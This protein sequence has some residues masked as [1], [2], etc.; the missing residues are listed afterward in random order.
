MDYFETPK[1][2]LSEPH[3]VKNFSDYGQILHIHFSPFEWTKD[4][5]L[6]A[7]TNKILFATLQFKVCDLI[8][9]VCMVFTVTSRR[10]W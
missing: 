2:Q 9:L 8:Q 10:T 7:F 6:L 4:V 3:Y 1:S 5:I